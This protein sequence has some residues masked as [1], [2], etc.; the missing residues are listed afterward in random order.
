MFSFFSGDG[1]GVGMGFGQ[2]TTSFI[3]DICTSTI[4]CLSIDIWRHSS[5]LDDERYGT[6]NSST[7]HRIQECKSCL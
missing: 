4:E 7:V 6:F 2:I 3:L 5:I 1:V